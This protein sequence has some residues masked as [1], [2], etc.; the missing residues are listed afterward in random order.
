MSHSILDAIGNTPLVE[1]RRLNPNPRVRILAKLE[2]MNPG[3]S[4]KDR[5][6]LQMILAGEESGRLTPEK[7]VIEA[8][9]GN[10]G[11][12]LALVCAVKGYRLL[13]TMSEAASLERR[14]I[15]QAR[16]AEIL[17]TPGHMGTD[18]AIEAVYR[19]AREE[20]D[21]YFMADQYNNE[22]NWRAHYLG[23][24]GNLGADRGPDFHPG[25]HH[26]HHRHP[27]GHVP[28]SQ[29]IRS[30]HPDRRR[31]ALSGPQA[32]GA[33]EHEGVLRAR[34]FRPRPAG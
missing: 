10:T 9:S 12:G 24:A 2:Y 19:L 26:G 8:T 32:P 22:A 23:T 13:L 31:G 11:I 33:Q 14:Q 21:R 27:D 4:I 3:G 25:G 20:P 17:L 5:A 15:L 18:G 1:I 30:G 28:A 29:G 7:T 34:K 6:A 16:G